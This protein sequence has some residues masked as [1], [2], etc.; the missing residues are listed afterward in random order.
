[1]Y[2]LTTDVSVAFLSAR[3]VPAVVCRAPVACAH[4]P[5]TPLPNPTHSA[6]PVCQR[7]HL[8]PTCHHPPPPPPILPEHMTQRSEARQLPM[9]LASR[10]ARRDPGV[11]RD[12]HR[13]KRTR[14]AGHGASR[15]T[16]TRSLVNE[17]SSQTARRGCPL[18]RFRQHPHA[19]FRPPPP[20]TPS[21]I[22]PPEAP[23]SSLSPRRATRPLSVGPLPF[24]HILPATLSGTETLETP[25]R[26][27]PHEH[28]RAAE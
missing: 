28:N 17:T 21:P 8:L 27:W 24:S 2:I 10:R 23:A 18:A 13:G 4:A 11:G 9:S 22:H 7:A 14:G 15:A 12:A 5:P 20:L 16:C 3:G 6:T 1:M 19:P 25:T 26:T